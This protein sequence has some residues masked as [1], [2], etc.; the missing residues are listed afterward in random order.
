MEFAGLFE[1][2][3]INGITLR[4]RIV[5][6]AMALFYADH[7][8]FTDRFKDFYRERARGGVGLMIMGPMAIDEQGSTPLMPG[9]FHD[10][11]VA[12]IKAFVRELHQ[13]ATTRLGMQLMHLGRYASSSVTGTQPI[14]PSPVASPI[15]GEVPR[16][17]RDEDIENAQHAFV[18]AAVRAKETG[19]DY[20]EIMAAGGYLIGEFLSEVSNRRTDD[21]GGSLENR[22]RFGLE[23]IRAVRRAL[24]KDFAL[25]M[26]VSGHDFVSGGNT[27]VESAAFCIEAEKAGIDCINVTGGWHE[28]NVP[29]ITSDVPVGTYVHLARSIKEKVTVPVFASNRLGDP[30]VAEKVLRSGAADAVCWGRPLIAD[31][32]LPM[33]AKEGRI[34][35]AAPC[36]ACNQGCLDSIFSGRPVWCTVNPRAGREANT[37]TKPARLKKRIYVA[38]GGPAGLQ[39]ALT[40]CQRGHRVV[41]YEKESKAGGQVNLV[42]AVPG[43]EEFHGAVQSLESRA[44]SA[45]VD[46]ALGNELTSEMLRNDPPDLLVVASGAKQSGL[47]IPGIEKS[48]VVSAWDILSGAVSPIGR[49]IVVVGGGATGCETA[50]YLAHL[51]VPTAETIAF[52]AFHDVHHPDVLRKLLHDS[53]R[54]ITI[55]EMADRPARTMGASTRWSALKKLKLMGVA[56]K[57]GVEIVGFEKESVSIRGRAGVESIH[58]DMVVIAAGSQ[59]V[60]DLVQS[61]QELGIETITIGDAKEPKKIGDAVREGFDAALTA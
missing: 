54:K 36:I 41:L 38:G 50:L 56:L 7:Y 21:Y 17:M 30:N 48:P 23:A 11:H 22:M 9:L 49:N 26:R 3:G 40:A 13:D 2:L 45:G 57:L 59:S 14:A 27:M 55:I 47:E 29:Q 61:A 51:S 42:A 12:P 44:K 46:I 16:E 35:E 4:N 58:A 6:P 37:E 60:N 34:D 43:K 52:L 28:T 25:G 10:G 39:F 18:A 31:P 19:L 32:D 53:G 20:V 8:A 24:G 1:P 15:T 33:K 5:M